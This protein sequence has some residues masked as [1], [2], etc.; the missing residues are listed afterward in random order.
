MS[1][2]QNPTNSNIGVRKIKEY[3]DFVQWFALPMN[4]REDEF[5]C[6]TQKQFAAK[7]DLAPDTLVDWKKRDDFDKRIQKIRNDW[8]REHTGSVFAGWRN[9]C[10]K[11]NPY[12]IELW[13]SYFLKWDK[14]QIV[15]QVQEFTKEDLLTLI[16]VLPEK[17]QQ[18]FYD[19]VNK[20]II[21]ANEIAHTKGNDSESG[22]VEGEDEC[23]FEKIKPAQADKLHEDKSAGNEVAEDIQ[24]NVRDSVDGQNKENN[25]QGTERR[26]KK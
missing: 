4:E 10:V 12:S 6:K 20:I 25:N 13:L 24:E 15:K 16:K 3:F 19:T 11:G 5:G 1:D 7:Y 22:K 18:Q 21:E 14:T 9:S 8:G 17:K 2:K 23:G 26:G